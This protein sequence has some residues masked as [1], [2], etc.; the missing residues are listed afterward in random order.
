M[1]KALLRL[2]QVKRNRK[3]QSEHM[4]KEKI[5]KIPTDNYEEVT[6][7]PLIDFF[8]NRYNKR[9]FN[10]I[11]VLQDHYDFDIRNNCG[12]LIATIDCILIETLE[13]YY[14]GED[15]ST[16]KNHDPFYCFFKRSEAFKNVIKSDKDAGRFAGLVRNGLLHQSKT[17]KASVINKRRSTPIIGW[18]NSSDKSKGFEI[19]RDLFHSNVVCEYH[20]LIENLKIPENN[21]LRVKFKSKILTLI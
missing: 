21:D 16:G 10:P 5:D 3:A 11:K 17:K 7:E 15:E 4:T 1:I 18:I 14:S 6:W 12:F 19:N 2:Q 9:Y 8:W 20:K 13:Q